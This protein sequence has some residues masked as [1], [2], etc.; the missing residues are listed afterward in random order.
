[1]RYLHFIGLLILGVSLLAG[2]NLSEPVPMTPTSETIPSIRLAIIASPTPAETPGRVLTS[3]STPTASA[4]P[5]TELPPVCQIDTARPRSRYEVQASLDYATKI[6][7]VSQTIRYANTSGQP[8][9]E[10]VLSVEPNQWAG[11]FK[12]TEAS[13]GTTPLVTELT[14]M[15]LH[16]TLPRP[17]EAGC[18]A[19][20]LLQFEIHV[21][22]GGTGVSMYRGYF[23]FGE[24]QL[25]LGYWLPVI[26]PLV[27]GQWLLHNPT[28][29]GEQMVL[30]PADWD[31]TLIVTNPPPNLQLAAPGTVETHNPNEWHILFEKARDLPLSLSDQFRV[32]KQMT[33]SGTMV[34]IYSF[35]DAMRETPNGLIDGAQHALEEA[36]RAFQQYNDLFGDYPYD[37][38]LVVQA[39][40]PDG[41]EASGLVFVS[42][43]WFSRFTGGVE[44]YLT[45]ITV[46]EVAHQWW[47]ARVGN[48]SALTP[49]LDESLATYSE[50]IYYE[51]YHPELKNWW[52]EFRVGEYNP[53]G[54][55]DSTI[56]EF[57]DPRAYIN[58]VYLRGVQMLQNLR[59]NIGTEAFF[60]LLAQYGQTANGQIATPQLFWSL[61][62]P[63]QFAATKA[64]R[65]QFFRDGQFGRP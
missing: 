32:A 48:D 11:I 59:E 28:S 57:D 42:T 65:A 49:W 8:L 39:D 45:V 15:R 54:S 31:V 21:P 46:H 61:L 36:A 2:C 24:R 19:E 10:L 6:I 52:W 53:T 4:L 47:Y 63:D 62:T 25:N 17:L 64:T 12:L 1:M 18:E 58:A 60:K 44:N 50:Y 20:L 5:P 13:W 23:S 40:F 27:N 33:A 51:E 35:A 3:L 22:R 55:V 43:N 29:I 16:V 41:M 56:Y 38:M 34:E 14:S 7:I 30:E 9:T 26:T 37:R